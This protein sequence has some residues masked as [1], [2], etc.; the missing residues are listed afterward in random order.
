MRHL[1]R[2]VQA[3]GLTLILLILLGALTLDGIYG[4]SGPRDL[5]VLRQH[6]DALARERDR[7]LADNA[8]IQHRIS[9]LRADDAYLEQL[10]RQE[11]GYARPG[12]IIYRFA[13][14]EQ[15]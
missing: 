2:G 8:L 12:E 6:S 15:P 13:N 7:L 11:L 5:L 1:S 14:T 4:P 3:Q 9:R 10:I